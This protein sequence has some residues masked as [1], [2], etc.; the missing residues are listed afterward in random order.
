MKGDKVANTGGMATEYEPSTNAPPFGSALNDSKFKPDVK[1]T[2]GKGKQL[3][4]Q[5]PR[6]V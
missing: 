3:K 6:R 4:S 2:V 1:A 5:M